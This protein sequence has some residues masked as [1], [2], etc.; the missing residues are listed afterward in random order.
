MNIKWRNEMDLHH[1]V[2]DFSKIRIEEFN[3]SI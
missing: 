1:E 2:I 3:K